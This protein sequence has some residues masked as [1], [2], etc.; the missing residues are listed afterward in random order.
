[1]AYYHSPSPQPYTGV[2]SPSI[3]SASSSS[4]SI[5]QPKPAPKAPKPVNVFSNDG[6]FLERVQRIKKEEG[7]KK[8]EEELQR[9]RNLDARFR[10]RGKRPLPD[11]AATTPSDD[12][13]Q[14]KKP[15]TVNP[16]Q[17]VISGKGKSLSDS[18]SRK[19]L[20]ANSK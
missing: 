20:K 9:K 8:N 4:S 2:Y 7:E 5:P 11:S 17:S 15:K 13:P 19:D 3:L 12:E 16:S 1:M 14:V 6:S 18:N 10:N